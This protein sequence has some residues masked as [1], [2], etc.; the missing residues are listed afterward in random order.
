MQSHEKSLAGPM[1]T[2]PELL[3]AANQQTNPSVGKPQ[4]RLSS[5]LVRAGVT[6]RQ[7]G[8]VFSSAP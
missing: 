6:A 2:L 3:A 4:A 8:S 7:H 1:P 5:N